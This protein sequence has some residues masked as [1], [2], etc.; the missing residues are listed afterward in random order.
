MP[1]RTLTQPKI[2][3]VLIKTHK[4]TVLTTV[5]PTI[6][7]GSLKAEVLSALSDDVNQADDVPQVS[8][9]EDFELSKGVKERGKLNGE[10]Q[11]L[12]DTDLQLKEAGVTNWE[13]LFVQ[14]RDPTSGELQPV[15]FVPFEDDEDDVPSQPPPPA[16]ESSTSRGKRKAHPE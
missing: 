15:V 8:A 3:Q 1:P 5:A 11:L 10:Y 16:A 7:V 9:L 14:F 4:L 12:E 6:T 13:V 2:F